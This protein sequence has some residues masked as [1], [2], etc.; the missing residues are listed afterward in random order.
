M[1]VLPWQQMMA[2]LCSA[3]ITTAVLIQR[4]QGSRTADCAIASEAIKIL[5]LAILKHL[6]YNLTGKIIPLGE[7]RG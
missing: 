2:A 4:T 1:A 7:K 6:P 3:L 5:G